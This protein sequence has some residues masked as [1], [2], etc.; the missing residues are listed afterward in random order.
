MNKVFR[1]LALFL[2]LMCCLM[3]SLA[4]EKEKALFFNGKTDFIDCPFIPFD[5]MNSFTIEVWVKNW[6]GYIINQGGAGDP[7]NGIWLST[8]EGPYDGCAWEVDQG[9][10][11]AINIGTLAVDQWTHIAMQFNGKEQSVFLNGLLVKK[12]AAPR[13]GPFADERNFI[14]AGIEKRL[15]EYSWSFGSG[16]LRSIKISSV[17]RYQDSFK[18]EENLTADGKTLL[19]YNQTS[20]QKS[21]IVDLSKNKC[22]GAVRGVRLLPI[23]EIHPAAISGIV[24]G[25]SNQPLADILVVLRNNDEYNPG[26]SLI[27]KTNNLG[28]Y[29]L[30]VN[31]PAPWYTMWAIKDS[32]AEE[33]PRFEIKEGEHATVNFLLNLSAYQKFSS[34]GALTGNWICQQTSADGGKIRR[35]LHCEWFYHFNFMKYS[36]SFKKNGEIRY[37]ENGVFSW[38]PDKKQLIEHGWNSF[39]DQNEMIVEITAGK[40]ILKVTRI[41]PNGEIHKNISMHWFENSNRLCIQEAQI[42]ANGQLQ[43]EGEVQVFR[44]VMN[45][46]DD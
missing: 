25:P 43:P 10:N 31:D 35:I 38:N 11:Y 27:A 46:S 20:L 19:L 8:D 21:K 3:P 14:I 30:L 41:S 2:L 22:N 37:E 4:A 26:T 32:L 39:G 34:L 6:S 36:L 28:E 5:K 33:K 17:I 24:R 45:H 29:K 1:V 18:P 9:K 12:Q 16:Y 42:D 40:I 23:D 13:P 44:R 15:P 7:E